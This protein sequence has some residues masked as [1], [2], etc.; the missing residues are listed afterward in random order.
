MNKMESHLT[1]TRPLTQRHNKE[2]KRLVFKNKR[3]ADAQ[4]RGV[5]KDFPQELP[6]VKETPIE[7]LYLP[8]NKPS[9]APKRKNFDLRESLSSIQKSARHGSGSVLSK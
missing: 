2:S 4:L 3:N 8:I 7:H 5:S 9:F 6:A 1:D